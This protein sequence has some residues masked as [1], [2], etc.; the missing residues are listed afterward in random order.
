VWANIVKRLDNDQFFSNVNSILTSNKVK[1]VSVYNT[2]IIFLTINI[3][4]AIELHWL[5]SN[6]YGKKDTKR[7]SQS[8][9][10]YKC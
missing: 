8:I 3:I 1:Q 5:L 10:F 9:R 2:L 6:L 7:D 4:L